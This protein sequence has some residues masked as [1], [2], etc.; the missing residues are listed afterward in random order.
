M[1][2]YERDDYRNSFFDGMCTNVFITLTNGV[3][4]TGFA[5]YLGMG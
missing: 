5:L 3:F 4:L 2:L 1:K